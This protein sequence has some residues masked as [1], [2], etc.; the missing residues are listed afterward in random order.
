MAVYNQRLSNLRFFR[1][2][3]RFLQLTMA[4]SGGDQI[5]R[6]RAKLKEVGCEAVRF[7]ELKLSLSLSLG[8]DGRHASVDDNDNDAC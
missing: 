5:P 3:A 6:L 1:I 7:R 4:R 2:K 8:Q